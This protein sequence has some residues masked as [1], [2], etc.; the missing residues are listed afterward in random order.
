[1]TQASAEAYYVLVACAADKEELYA[2]VVVALLGVFVHVVG[3]DLNIVVAHASVAVASAVD[4]A[5]A[6]QQ[7]ETSCHCWETVFSSE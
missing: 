6:K 2:V 4:N 5:P 3:A 7:V 1:M